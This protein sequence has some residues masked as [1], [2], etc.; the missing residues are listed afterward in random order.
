MS[1]LRE[2]Y[3]ALA[4]ERASVIQLMAACGS[5]SCGCPSQEGATPP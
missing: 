4:K 3:D 2:Q 5:S 1:F